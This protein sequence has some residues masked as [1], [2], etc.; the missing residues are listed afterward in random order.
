MMNHFMDTGELLNLSNVFP[1][2][3]PDPVYDYK[4]RLHN[5][6]TGPKTT[7]P[8]KVPASLF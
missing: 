1:D 3:T 5:N 7:R 4:A 8:Q 6:Y 2:E